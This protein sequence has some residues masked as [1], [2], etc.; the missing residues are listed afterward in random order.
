MSE[1]KLRRA[2]VQARYSQGL[3]TFLLIEF[4]FTALILYAHTDSVEGG[5]LLFIGL[6]TGLF[7]PVIAMIIVLFYTAFWSIGI[8]IM[9]VQSFGFF[10]GVPIGLFGS[11]VMLSIHLAGV[12]G[13][14]DSA[15]R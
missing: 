4:A 3:S 15:F 6:V 13:S 12:S 7:V 10:A 2:I 8:C 11:F 14:H 5:V 1:Y 9:C